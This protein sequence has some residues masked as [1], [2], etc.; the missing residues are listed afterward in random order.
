[1]QKRL[2]LAAAVAAVLLSTCAFATP[3]LAAT[4][5]QWLG[6]YVPGSPSSM[7]PV[8]T[9]ENQVGTHA[10]VVN[11]FV[12]DS[13]AFPA[14]RCANI[15]AVG[16]T[17]LV[18]LEFWSTQTG[19]LSSI[20]DGSHDA[21][22]KTF[23]AAAKAYG[24]PV[25]LRPFHEMNGNWY[26][27]GTVTGNTPAKLIA[28]Y[29]HVH[30]VF[31]AAGATN[32]KFVWCPNV[33]FNVSSFYPGDAY[34][35][36]AAIDGYNNGAPWRSFSSIFNP[37]YDAV[38]AVSSKPIFVAETSSVEGGSGKAAWIAAMFSQIATRDTR[39][40]GV[41]WFNAAQTYD[42]RMDTSA[43]SI[44]AL[45]S[46]F[47]GTTYQAAVAPT[48]VA[49]SVTIKTSVKSVKRKHAIKISGVLKPGRSGSSVRITVSIPKHAAS[50]RRVTT[51][52]SG[53]W[54]FKY[55][56]TVRGTYYLRV[57]FGGDS[58]RRASSSKTIKLV[59]K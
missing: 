9:A 2:A 17:P 54:S 26:P 46:G 53:A 51:A 56:P 48:P 57:T 45:K 7:A 25:W 35:D 1:M 5:T 16:A 13:E 27:W 52:S 22:L 33:D 58:T 11:F 44:A 4:T 21:Y 18:T 38:A 31:A 12:S 19:G 28:A 34:V 3:A 42:W 20:T 30:D 29:R 6:L 24:R 55:T 15:D 41:C 8:S 23:A 59:V 43:S 14:P 32:V 39:I 40:A 37:T 50:G 36:Y 49:S 47:A 10:A